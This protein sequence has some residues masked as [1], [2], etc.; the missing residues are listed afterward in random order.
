MKRNR[1]SQKLE[2]VRHVLKSSEAAVTVGNTTNV[3]HVETNR[4][5]SSDHTHYILV[6]GSGLE[7]SVKDRGKP[8]V[9]VT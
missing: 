6:R 7:S 9:M 1:I 3:H 5:V 2:Q 8:V 4:V